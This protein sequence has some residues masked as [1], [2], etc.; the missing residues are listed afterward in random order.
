MPCNTGNT[1][2][3]FNF[4]KLQ[5]LGVEVMTGNGEDEFLTK[6]TGK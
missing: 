3:A 4:R 6:V 5:E 2:S 1:S